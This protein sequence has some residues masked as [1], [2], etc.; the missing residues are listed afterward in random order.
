MSSKQKRKGWKFEHL[1]VNDLK[2]LGLRVERAGQANQPDIV[3]DGFGVIECKCWKQGLKTAYD[4][5]G[6]NEAAVVKWQSPKARGKEPI[7][8]LKYED[9]KLLLEKKLG[10]RE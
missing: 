4:I 8:F 7:V 6:G 2:A 1:I 10:V 9:F 3:V 5:L